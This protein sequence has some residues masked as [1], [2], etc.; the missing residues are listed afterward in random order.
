MEV[1]EKGCGANFMWGKKA[2]M[3]KCKNKQTKNGRPTLDTG[4][5]LFYFIYFNGL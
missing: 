3:N 4:W 5:N 1:T 2:F